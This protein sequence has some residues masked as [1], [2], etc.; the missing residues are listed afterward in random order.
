MS[1]AD[2]SDKIVKT[3]IRQAL[4]TRAEMLVT[5]CPT[6]EQVLK[7]AAVSSGD[8]EKSITVRNLG[9]LVWQAIK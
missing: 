6:C 7:A 9:D 2:L 3:R 1:D 8:K 4:N 5:S